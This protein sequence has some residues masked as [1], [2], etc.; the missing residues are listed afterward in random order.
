[1]VILGNPG[2]LIIPN[3]VII[4]LVECLPLSGR[5]DAAFYRCF[6]RRLKAMLKG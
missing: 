2:Q 4:L 6:A 1:M 5:P 3:G